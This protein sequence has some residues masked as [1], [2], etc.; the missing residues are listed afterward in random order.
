MPGA[1]QRRACH[2][3]GTAGAGRAHGAPA[4]STHR[5]A[6]PLGTDEH[7]RAHGPGMGRG[8]HPIAEHQPGSQAGPPGTL[9]PGSWTLVRSTVP[10]RTATARWSRRSAGPRSAIG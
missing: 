3:A 9:T 8:V 10:D 1:G 5:T 6:D 2:G 7:H 4:P